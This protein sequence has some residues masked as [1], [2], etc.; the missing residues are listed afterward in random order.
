[1]RQA[2][3]IGKPTNP[4]HLNGVAEI[5]P[6][7]NHFTKKIIVLINNLDFSASEFFAAILQDN[8]RAILFGERTAGAGGCVRR[9]PGNQFLG[10]EYWTLTWTMAWRTIGQPIENIGVH[11]DIRYTLTAKDF[12]FGFIDYHQALLTGHQPVMCST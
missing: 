3:G 10:E 8:K 5:L 12:Q 1:M 9:M 2:R 7:K 4:V 11:P 6:A